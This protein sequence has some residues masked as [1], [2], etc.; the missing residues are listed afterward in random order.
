M[1]KDK[2][3]L[4]LEMAHIP[5]WLV[6]DMCWLFT[7][8]TTGMVMAIPTVV[9]AIIIAWA[10]RKDETKFLP[11]LSIALWIIANANWMVAEFYEF[12]TRFYSVIP[13]TLG[14][15]VFVVFLLN[16]ARKEIPG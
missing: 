1:N 8:R 15:L 11:N 14:I 12:K 13:F 4:L 2:I 7:W 3:L 16:R 9:V 10:T 5:L 6:K